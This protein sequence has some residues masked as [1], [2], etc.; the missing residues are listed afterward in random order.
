MNE[1]EK[2][3]LQSNLADLHSTDHDRQNSAF[4]F[5][6]EAT[7]EPVEWAYTVWDDLMSTLKEGDNRQRAIA[8]QVLCGL[9]KSDPKKRM[10]QDLGALL[11]VTKDER[12]VTARHCMQSLWKVGVAGESQ[13]KALVQGLVERFQECAAEKNCTLIRYDILESL[14]HIYDVAGDEKLWATATQLMELEPDPK[15]KKKYGTLWRKKA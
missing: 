2:E 10:R 3:H 14:R 6:I 4:Q 8:A 13:R 9:A 12:V 15:Y 5:F 7:N 11:E 1:V